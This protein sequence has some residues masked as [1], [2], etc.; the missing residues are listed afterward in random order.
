MFACLFVSCFILFVYLINSLFLFIFISL[1]IF[2]FACLQ[3]YMSIRWLQSS[4]SL[5]NDS[6]LQEI[7]ERLKNT[8]MESDRR[9]KL[10][11]ELRHEIEK[12]QKTELKK[13]KE[14]S[15]FIDMVE[16]VTDSVAFFLLFVS[17]LLFF[18]FFF[19]GL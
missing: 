19:F 1:C 3:R 10:V 12:R 2:C 11:D 6:Y 13:N 17:S 7:A 9:G 15:F 4:D 5:I 18:S 14:V 8:E 16:A